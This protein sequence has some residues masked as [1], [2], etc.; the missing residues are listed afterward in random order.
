MDF[1]FPFVLTGEFCRFLV[2]QIEYPADIIY[3]GILSIN[4]ITNGGK[5]EYFK[6]SVVSSK[7]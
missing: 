2:K 5:R 3:T 6:V 7:S 1:Q 4:R